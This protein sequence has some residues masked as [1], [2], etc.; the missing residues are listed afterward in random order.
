MYDLSQMIPSE[1]TSKYQY[2]VK[3][4]Q[5]ELLGTI[6]EQT[7]EVGDE[8]SL[9]LTIDDL[10]GLIQQRKKVKQQQESVKATTDRG[11]SSTTKNDNRNPLFRK[12][13][14]K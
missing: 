3:R 13:A 10:S 6:M 8:E 7:E 9:A 12:W 5:D 4:D 2:S 11:L 1:I 14:M